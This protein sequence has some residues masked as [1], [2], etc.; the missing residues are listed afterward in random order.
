MDDTAGRG[1]DA[2][3][4]DPA[5]HATGGR[6]ALDKLLPQA[7]CAPADAPQ[8]VWEEA[9]GRGHIYAHIELAKHYEHKMRDAKTSIT[10]A[11]SARVEVEKAD[12]PA[13]IRK[14]WLGEIDHRLA[15][16]ERKAGL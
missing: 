3:N 14:H 9:A 4:T 12:L 10:W 7:P 8:L 13:Y 2:A 5:A 16:L 11:K 6:A 1:A 15:R